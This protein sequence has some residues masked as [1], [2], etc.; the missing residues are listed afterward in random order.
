[1]GIAHIWPF[2]GPLPELLAT[3]RAVI[4][5]TYPGDV[6]PYVGATLPATSSGRG[7]RVQA[8]RAKSAATVLAWAKD[9]GVDLTPD[10]V[11]ELNA[12]FGSSDDGE[13]RFDAVMGALGMIAVLQGLRAEGLPDNE[14]VREIEGWIFGRVATSAPKWR[15]PS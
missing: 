14:T 15:P 1:M 8:S 6:Y 2:D 11:Y 12:G 4:V 7:K 10:L 13:D 9:A 3:R 5:E